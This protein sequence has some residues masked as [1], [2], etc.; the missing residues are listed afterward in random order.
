M[1]LLFESAGEF[2]DSEGLEAATSG[3]CMAGYYCVLG[4]ESNM[5]TDGI[6]GDAC[7]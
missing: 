1:Q 3:L 5:P 7:P 6:T 2:C 4:S